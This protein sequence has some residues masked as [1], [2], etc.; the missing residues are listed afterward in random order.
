MCT[1]TRC[2]TTG[3]EGRIEV[4][5]CFEQMD[6]LILELQNDPAGSL[7]PYN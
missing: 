1:N 3:L 5:P 6:R 2:A 7:Y 4:V